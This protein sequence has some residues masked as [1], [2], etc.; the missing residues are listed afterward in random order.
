[1]SLLNGYTVPDSVAADKPE[2]ITRLGLTDA[3]RLIDDFSDAV[4]AALAILRADRATTV[5]RAT[6]AS[7]DGTPDLSTLDEETKPFVAEYDRAIALCEDVLM[8]AGLR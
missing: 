2:D 8:K 7:P 4:A 3:A 1:M 6:V 5:E